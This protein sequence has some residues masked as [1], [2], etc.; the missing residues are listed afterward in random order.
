[1]FKIFYSNL[2]NF[3]GSIE[4]NLLSL[5]NLIKH[6]DFYFVH[7]LFNF[8]LEIHFYYILQNYKEMVLYQ[9]GFGSW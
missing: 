5:L 3:I 4:F 7:L 9:R 6:S 8:F 1:M 2:S